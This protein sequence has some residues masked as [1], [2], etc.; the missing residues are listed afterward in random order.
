MSEFACV[1]LSIIFLMPIIVHVSN[2]ATER[3]RARGSAQRSGVGAGDQAGPLTRKTE[4]VEQIEQDFQTAFRSAVECQ[5][6]IRVLQECEIGFQV[7]GYTQGKITQDPA[8]KRAKEYTLTNLKRVHADCSSYMEN[9]EAVARILEIKQYVGIAMGLCNKCSGPEN[10]EG[11][12]RCAVLEV[13]SK[14]DA[15]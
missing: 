8:W 12:F 1:L 3:I 13:L 7:L 14:L 15:K 5:K 2:R 4:L 10:E 9:V 11:N 6:I